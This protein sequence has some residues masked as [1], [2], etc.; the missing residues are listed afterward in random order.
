[1]TAPPGAQP[2]HRTLAIGVPEYAQPAELAWSVWEYHP[3][4]GQYVRVGELTRLT[5][6]GRDWRAFVVVRDSVTPLEPFRARSL[7]A[8]VDEVWGRAYR[9]RAGT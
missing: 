6:T 3:G 1:M 4:S 8:A 9:E 5:R 7:A 2:S